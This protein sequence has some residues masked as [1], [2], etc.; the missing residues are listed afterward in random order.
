MYIFSSVF[1]LI[2]AI[3]RDYFDITRIVLVESQGFVNG[4]CMGHIL[5]V[6]VIMVLFKKMFFFTNCNS[7][8]T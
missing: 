6:F 2:C 1:M 3:R 4:E 7:D 5:E 8:C